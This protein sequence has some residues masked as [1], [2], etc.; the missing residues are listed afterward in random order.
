M[1]SR[2]RRI[3]QRAAATAHWN[4]GATRHGTT[5]KHIIVRSHAPSPLMRVLS[6]LRGLSRAHTS[7]GLSVPPPVCARV[8]AVSSSGQPPLE[9]RCR[10]VARQQ[11]VIEPEDSTIA[12]IQRPTLPPN[13]AAGQCS[14]RQ[15][16]AMTSTAGAAPDS[17]RRGPRQASCPRAPRVGCQ[18]QH[19]ECLDVAVQCEQRQLAAVPRHDRQSMSGGTASPARS[20][21][22]SAWPH[23]R[24]CPADA[25]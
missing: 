19:D 12:V 7:R 9:R 23:R 17:L 15:T 5:T 20:R 18:M 6:I 25:P 2:T 22:C 11:H 13:P 4:G 14:L 16:L 21:K 8:H 3:E 1:R 10:A 24:S